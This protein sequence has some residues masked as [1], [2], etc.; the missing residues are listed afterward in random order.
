VNQH[1]KIV[2][3]NFRSR[4]GSTPQYSDIIAA[5]YASKYTGRTDDE[6]NFTNFVHEL[7]S[8][9]D[10]DAKI[11]GSLCPMEAFYYASQEMIGDD[12]NA[13]KSNQTWRQMIEDLCE[14]LQSSHPT[15][16]LTGSW[17]LAWLMERYATSVQ[18]SSVLIALRELAQ[19]VAKTDEPEILRQVVWAIGSLPVVSRELIPPAFFPSEIDSRLKSVFQSLRQQHWP[20][21]PE[22]VAL[23]ISFYNCG[24]LS[25]SDLAAQLIDIGVPR[26]GLGWT[27]HWVHEIL[28]QLGDT[29]K[30]A[31]HQR[32]LN[33][34]GQNRPRRS[35]RRRRPASSESTRD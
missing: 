29:G 10:I 9:E 7:L 8:S 25:D 33:A 22:R 30:Q 28:S 26:I 17:A 14:L 15:L 5:I 23:L 27:R 31:I 34:R 4:N 24:P 13:V 3:E 12:K 2:M 16:W 1:I 21:D 32:A 20:I 6:V 35:S 19:V 18:E 11:G